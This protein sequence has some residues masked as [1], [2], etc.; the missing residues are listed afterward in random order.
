MTKNFSYFLAKRYLIPKGLFMILINV[1]TIVG[2]CLGVAVMIVVLSVMKGFENEFQRTLLGFDPHL[3]A[4]DRL[5]LEG[6]PEAPAYR[7]VGEKIEKVPGVV[8]QSPYVAGPV[9][10]Q[11]GNQVQTPIM[12]AILPSDQQLQELKDREMLEEGDLD[13]ETYVDEKSTFERVIVLRI[14]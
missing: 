7:E 1:L 8:S 13:L 12:K 4:L 10:V 2:V 14:V 11:V 5:G 9:M 6:D 3:M